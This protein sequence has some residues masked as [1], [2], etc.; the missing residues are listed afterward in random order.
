MSVG[1]KSINELDWSTARSRKDFE[2]VLRMAAPLGEDLMVNLV[3]EMCSKVNTVVHLGF[4]LT[5]VSP[6]GVP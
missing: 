5:R 2:G 1:E 6:E 3:L 4:R